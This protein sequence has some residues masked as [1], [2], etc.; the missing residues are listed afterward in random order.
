[1]C[2]LF[3]QLYFGLSFIISSLNVFI[4]VQT[5]VR[6]YEMMMIIGLLKRISENVCRNWFNI[7]IKVIDKFL[8][9]SFKLWFI[10]ICMFSYTMYNN[11]NVYTLVNWIK[12]EKWNITINIWIYTSIFFF[13][14]FQYKY[15]IY[16]IWNK[17]DIW[18]VRIVVL[19]VILYCY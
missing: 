10:Y 19:F 4:H 3:L 14:L 18:K 15:G 12:K 8:R 5:Y 13:V 9:K 7:F 2:H 16:C 11:I 17:L 1:M 6:T